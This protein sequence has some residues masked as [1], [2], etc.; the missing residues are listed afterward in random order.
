[1][2]VGHFTLIVWLFITKYNLIAYYNQLLDNISYLLLLQSC[3]WHS[4][5]SVMSSPHSDVL[6]L[7][8]TVSSWVV[9]AKTP[10]RPV[11]RG[12][13]SNFNIWTERNQRNYKRYPYYIENWL[14]SGQKILNPN[15]W[16][17][18]FRIFLKMLEKIG[19]IHRLIVQLFIFL[20]KQWISL[21]LHNKSN[22]RF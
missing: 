4:A 2:S 9:R 13:V 17:L 8:C 15:K 22:K 19:F 12:T 7:I 21:W 5:V 6:F 18:M 10:V 1:M 20:S 16:C 3:G 11:R 14:N